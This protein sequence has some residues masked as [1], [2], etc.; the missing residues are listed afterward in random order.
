[1]GVKYYVHDG[2]KSYTV[3]ISECYVLKS[4]IS[5]GNMGKSRIEIDNMLFE[6]AIEELKK[7]NKTLWGYRRKFNFLQ[8]NVD[9][10]DFNDLW[11]DELVEFELKDDVKY[12]RLS[13][14]GKEAYKVYRKKSPN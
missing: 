9:W 1:M 6:Y 13:D 2:E 14:K 12:Y 3:E 11:V 10:E 4:L 8:G 5:D 7:I